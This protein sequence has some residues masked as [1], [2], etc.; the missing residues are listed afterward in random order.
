[1]EGRTRPCTLLLQSVWLTRTANVVIPTTA[2]TATVTRT[3]WRESAPTSSTSSNMV[4]AQGELAVGGGDAVVPVLQC[5]R[6]LSGSSGKGI[7]STV[8]IGNICIHK[9][10][11]YV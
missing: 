6:L 8:N 4:C 1:M 5:P 3:A 11:Q 7:F 2:T 9:L 10:E